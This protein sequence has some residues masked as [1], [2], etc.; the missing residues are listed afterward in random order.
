MSSCE[1]EKDR[2]GLTN[3]QRRNAFRGIFGKLYTPA[4]ASFI[5]SELSVSGLG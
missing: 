3:T 2:M 5:S 4:I 1:H